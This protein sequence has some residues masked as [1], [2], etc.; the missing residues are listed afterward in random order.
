MVLE[1]NTSTESETWLRH[2]K[3]SVASINYYKITLHCRSYYSGGLWA[4]RPS[5]RASILAGEGDFSLLIASRL[6]PISWVLGALYAGMRWLGWDAD[7]S[8][9]PPAHISSRHGAGQLHNHLA[10]HCRLICKP[11]NYWWLSYGFRRN[12]SIRVE[13]N[14]VALVTTDTTSILTR[15]MKTTSCCKWICYPFTFWWKGHNIWCT[16][17]PT[18]QHALEDFCLYKI[19][20]GKM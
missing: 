15:K 17:H 8:P 20:I 5:N 6:A 2:S 12:V 13:K 10:F 18:I 14:C 1:S 9:T 7:H 11:H 3:I 4:G 16:E 19:K